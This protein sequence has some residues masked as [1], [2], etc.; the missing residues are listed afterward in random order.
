[1]NTEA[2]IQTYRSTLD[3]LDRWIDANRRPGGSWISPSS[4]AGYFSLPPYALEVGHLDWAFTT[5][6]HVEGSFMGADD[7]LQQGA[8]RDKMLPY[9]P[10][11]L[12]WGANKTEAFRLASSLLDQ[13]LTFRSPS[14]GFFGT[15]DGRKTGRGPVDFDSTTIST[16]ALAQCGR[17]GDCTR[18]AD[19]LVRLY[20]EQGEIGTSF[21]TAWSEPEGLGLVGDDVPSTA[22]LR[23]AEP[24]QHYYKIG[25]FTLALAYA[26]GATGHD[27]YLECG[28]E[29][30]ER[31]IASAVDLFTNTLSHKMCWAATLLHSITGRSQYLEHACR[32]ADHLASL[33]QEDGAFTYPELWPSYPPTP[34][35][36]VPNAGCQFGLWI[37][38]TLSR[39]GSETEIPRT[40]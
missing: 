15:E 27:Q 7:T 28:V 37:A 23:W 39:L 2:R 38:R 11:W 3:R 5:I 18:T 36:L 16:I 19:F 32:F 31:T 35:E 12:A 4:P 13:I 25:L 29:L 1:M 22:I 24:S 30:Y 17:V 10:A 33:Q 26:Y 8:K 14:G 34:W 21:C 20:R 9:V 40:D 6:R